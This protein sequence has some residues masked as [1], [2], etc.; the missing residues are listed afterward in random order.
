MSALLRLLAALALTVAVECSATALLLGR[1]AAYAALLCNL[2]TNPLLNALLLLCEALWPAGR[3]P[4]WCC[5]RP[6]S[7]PVKPRYLRAC[8]ARPCASH[9]AFLL[10]NALSFGAGLLLNE[11]SCNTQGGLP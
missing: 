3:R 11:L 6:P 9:C 5:W 1:R 4:R 7:W 10:L 8:C 2:L